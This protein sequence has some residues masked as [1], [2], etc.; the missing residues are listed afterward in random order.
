[1]KGY[2]AEQK[3]SKLAD[4]RVNLVYRDVCHSV[5]YNL[6]YIYRTNIHKA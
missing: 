4:E 3:A 2:V 6:F 1:M 5:F